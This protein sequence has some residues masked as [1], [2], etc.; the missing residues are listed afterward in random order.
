MW[1]ATYVRI[2]HTIIRRLGNGAGVNPGRRI[3]TLAALAAAGCAVQPPMALTPSG[4]AALECRDVQRADARQPNSITWLLPDDPTHRAK[5]DAVCRGVGPVAVTTP[6]NAIPV[7]TVGSAAPTVDRLVVVSWNTYLGRG[8]LPE[9][10]SQLTRGVFT[11]GRRVDTFVLLL[12]EVYRSQIQAFARD[13]NLHAVF[14]PSRR[15]AGEADDRGAAILST[16]PMTNLLLVE[17]P[18]EKQR[19]IALGATVEHSETRRQLRLVNVHF[20]TNVGLLRGGPSTARRRQARALIDALRHWPAPLVIAG[21]LNTWWGDDEPAV[22]ALRRDFPEAVPL[23]ARETWRGPLGMGN[24]LDYVFAKGMPQPVTVRRLAERF[25]SDHWPLLTVVP[26]E[27][28]SVSP[29][30]TR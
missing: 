30:P 16:L 2:S 13:R 29:D 25:G 24:K 26:L 1:C 8:D 15:R 20:D 19:R 28:L 7:G 10:L 23:A 12:Q 3:L 21:D 9:L 14:A 4:T 27:A 6:A 11:S 17:L 5:L 18:F 22:K